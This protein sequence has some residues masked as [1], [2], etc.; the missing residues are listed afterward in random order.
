MF[1]DAKLICTLGL[2]LV[3]PFQSASSQTPEDSANEPAV[4]PASAEKTFKVS[5]GLELKLLLSEPLITQPLMVSFD[6]QGRLWLVEYRQYPNPEGL[7]V[8]SKDRHWRVVYDSVPKPPGA[9]G[10][11][12]R[13]RISV[14]EDK[15]NDGNYESH[16]VFVDGLNIATA[17]L[18]VDR[19]AWVLNPPYLLYYSDLDRDLKA[20][21]PPQVHLEGFGLEDTHS[22][23]NNLT[24][25]PDG[26]IYGAQGSTVSGVVKAPGSAEKPIQSLG[27]AI[28]RYHP[29]TRKYEIF[30]EGGGNAFGVAFDD[31]GEVFSGHNGGDT[32]GFHYYQGGYYRKGFSKHGSL[33][34]PHSYGYLEPMQHDPIPRFTHTMLLTES[35][36]LASQTNPQPDSK[37]MLGVDPL[38]GKL[39]LTDL[40]PVGSTY[41][42][43]DVT[44]T[45]TSTDK[46]YRPVAI[47]DGPDGAAYVCD[48][49]DS[50]VAHLYAFEGRLDR[51]R[52]RVYRLGSSKPS[53]SNDDPFTLD[54]N[55]SLSQ[56]ADAQSLGKLIERLDH[57]YRWQ[58]WQ[59]RSLIAVHPLRKTC[60]A[61]LSEALA[62]NPP[63]VS[64][65]LALE[66]LWTL[67]AL[68]AI[69]DT[70]PAH[71]L[72]NEPELPKPLSP[73]V[74]MN[75]PVADVRSWAVRLVCDDGL[76]D[77]QTLL[78]IRELAA[79]ET[80]PHALCQI[81]CSARRLNADQALVV[82]RE[83]LGKPRAQDD[84]FF[85]L[86][87]WWAV[88]SH[89]QEFRQIESSLLTS[90]ELWKNP[91]A[92]KTV[93]PN[94]VRRW[95]SIGSQEAYASIATLL[96]TIGPLDE[97]IQSEATK[98]CQESFEA[99]FVGRSLAGVPDSVIDAMARLGQP[100]LTLQVRRGD[101]SAFAQAAKRIA[102]A[103][104]PD[105]TRMQLARLAGELD[106][107][108]KYPELLDALL[109][110]AGDASAKGPVRISAI[111]ALSNFNADSVPAQLIA[112]WPML[113]PELRPAAGSV[114]STRALWTSRWLDAVDAKQVDAEQLPPESIRTMRLHPDEALQKRLATAYPEFASV[115]L[116]GATATSR[117]LAEKILSGNGDP[118]KGKKLYRELCGR[119][120]QLFDDGGRVGPDLTGYQRDQL[121]TLLRNIVGPSLEIREGYQMVRILTDDSLVLTG[122]IESEQPDQIV[123][124]NTDGQSV[125]MQR[126][127]IEQL[128]P[129][130]LSLMPEG[131]L[132]KLDENQLR[133]LMAYLRSSQPLNDGT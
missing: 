82:V 83:L 88:E 94:L 26:W 32:R 132:E 42:T 44:E 1:A 107:A 80:D 34:N 130:V 124:R 40:M 129:Q 125:T 6:S 46:W 111:S 12:G 113:A 17:V 79:S 102:D 112:W 21:G 101:A 92:L 57:P 85:G 73:A 60:I 62:A 39:I 50:V 59:A 63:A 108:S 29:Q 93:F 105:A 51:D 77:P 96:R 49:Y 14:H 55:A 71:A 118:Y 56:A 64:S 97:S 8:L 75:H 4:E 119:C 5:D 25:G 61:K 120:H 52:G 2:L 116:A 35:T 91:I 48:W 22:V 19:G 98:R 47:C 114:L 95:A 54:W 104:A 41:K 31:R 45:V 33:S 38:H 70:I 11:V 100:P 7:K 127:E 121:E 28:W 109:Q 9:G 103:S 43:K 20:D 74:L 117:Q 15:D 53:T 81:A 3:L 110:V 126:S 72:A 24:M 89:A 76:V 106:D 66:Y 131:L 99:A 78:A 68:G 86:L 58:R 18:P 23:V 69:P 133:D 87:V 123:L 90:P 65:R 10:L 36:A 122:F 16:Q 27:Q 30:A 84:P 115:S 67:H 13:D 37:R 128:E